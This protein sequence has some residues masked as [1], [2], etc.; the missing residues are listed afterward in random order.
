MR[1]PLGYR[2][3]RH[4][5]LMTT[6][7]RTL[8]EAHIDRPAVVTIGSF[9]GVHRGHAALIRTVMEHARARN[10]VSVVITL[11]PHP[12]LILRPDSGLRLLST[13]EERIELL[14]EQGV[15]YV[16][17]FPFSQDQ[18]RLR[19]NEFIRF[20]K[21]H[22]PMVELVC[23]PNF[24]LG[25]K[26]EGTIPV[27]RELGEQ[28]GF[29][30]SVIEPQQDGDTPIS[31]SRIREL[32]ANG[33]VSAAAELLGRFPV[34]HGSVVHGDHRGRELGYN[35]AN[36]DIDPLKLIPANGIYA[37]RVR[38]GDEWLD[39]AASIG[40]RPTFGVGRLQV[41]IFLMDFS[42]W[43]YG[44]ELAAYFVERLRG[45]LKFDSVQALL[46]QMALDIVRIRE[47]LAQVPKG[48][49]GERPRPAA[50]EVAN[51]AP[52]A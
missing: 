8:S 25:H 51:S 34:L 29:E 38:L 23:G 40:I 41:E 42:R 7:I 13:W 49:I 15:D 6:I 22:V 14:A 1:Q 44:E 46:E 2:I 28:M 11:H 5:N 50:A 31:S 35:T 30:V 10:A 52:N 43:I 36:M 16:I 39:G 21:N 18:S 47:I 3:R 45:E 20:L 17:G 33:D 37:V 27:L 26:R 19:A 48:S 9:D 24:A 32:I 12:K 4:P